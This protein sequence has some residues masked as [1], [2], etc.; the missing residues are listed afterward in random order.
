MSEQYTPNEIPKK[1][2]Q[3]IYTH[4]CYHSHY[5]WATG[6]ISHD[7]DDRSGDSYICIAQTPITVS[8]PEQQKD[9]KK[10][11]IDA[12]E[13]EKKKQMAEYHQ[14]MCELQEKIDSLL[15]LE[16]KPNDIDGD[17]A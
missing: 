5:S 3:I 2:E 14:K 17:L 7:M 13:I 11:V 10:M 6:T 4:Y 15:A 8:V 9:I 16:Y 1:F 12:L